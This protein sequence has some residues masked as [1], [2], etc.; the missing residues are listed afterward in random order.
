MP[1]LGPRIGEAPRGERP[2]TT[3]TQALSGLGTGLATRQQR[4]GRSLELALGLLGQQEQAG[5]TRGAAELRARTARQ[6]AG[7]KAAADRLGRV[8]GR[9]RDTISGKIKRQQRE[10]DRLGK[11][12][13]FEKDEDKVIR[14][15]RFEDAQ[16][17]L[18]RLAGINDSV[19]N[20]FGQFEGLG[21]LAVDDAAKF[22]GSVAGRGPFPLDK[23]GLIKFDTRSKRELARLLQ[24]DQLSGVQGLSQLAAELGGFDIQMPEPGKPP[25]ELPKIGIGG[26]LT[27]I[28]G[29]SAP[30]EKLPDLTQPLE[31]D[32]SARLAAE[33]QFLRETGGRF[34]NA[35]PEQAAAFDKITQARSEQSAQENVLQKRIQLH[36]SNLR[37]EAP[38]REQAPGQLPPTAGVPLAPAQGATPGPPGFPPAA[39]PSPLPAPTPGLSLPGA[40]PPAAGDLGATLPTPAGPASAFEAELQSQNVA[41]RL[42]EVERMDQAD[43][44]RFEEMLRDFFLS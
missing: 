42:P 2:I 35:T 26:S 15:Q 27:A 24:N 36:L 11:A 30:P 18:A 5:A 9:I 25:P 14:E 38:F 10:V 29:P 44:T 34:G 7:S 23:E 3:I 21:P 40:P 19:T 6:T 28:F 22:L 31:L 1:H 17:E 43:R 16:R 32:A 4:A 37:R 8:E 33:V 13:Q 39:A 20:V 12:P 41:S